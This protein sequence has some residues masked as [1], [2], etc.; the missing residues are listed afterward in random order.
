MEKLSEKIKNKNQCYWT[1][2]FIILHLCSRAK[3]EAIQNKLFL[4][5]SL[6]IHNP[7]QVTKNGLQIFVYHA[8]NFKIEYQDICAV[9]SQWIWKKK[10]SIWLF[11]FNPT[12]WWIILST[13]YLVVFEDIFFKKEELLP[14][15]LKR[16]VEPKCREQIISLSWPCICP[17][18]NASFNWLL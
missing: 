2:K 11:T 5:Y 18:V 17:E 6:K 15:F 7:L 9:N 13:I 1:L 12:A 10:D 16:R 3:H 4:H 14:Y 8:F